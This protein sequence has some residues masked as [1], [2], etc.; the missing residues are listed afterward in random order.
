MRIDGDEEIEIDINR[1]EEMIINIESVKKEGK[2]NEEVGKSRFEV[3]DMGEDRKIEN[4]VK[5]CDNERDLKE[6]KKI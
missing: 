4:M 2:L 6:R 3:V 5:W 1:V